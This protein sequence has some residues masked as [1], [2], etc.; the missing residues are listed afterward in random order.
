MRTLALGL[1]PMCFGTE[2]QKWTS[3]MGEGAYLRLQGCSDPVG[4]HIPLRVSGT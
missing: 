2:K 3:Y 1:G 4:R